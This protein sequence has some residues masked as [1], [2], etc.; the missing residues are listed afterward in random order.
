[1]NTRSTTFATRVSPTNV[2][3]TE[4][5]DSTNSWSYGQPNAN[6]VQ[7]EIIYTC[8]SSENDIAQ[9]THALIRVPIRH[10]LAFN[11]QRIAFAESLLSRS[12]V[13]ETLRLIKSRCQSSQSIQFG[14]HWHS[15]ARRTT[16]LPLLLGEASRNCTGTSFP[17]ANHRNHEDPHMRDLTHRL[18]NQDAHPDSRISYPTV[19]R[20]EIR[21]ASS[22]LFIVVGDIFLGNR[23]R[24]VVSYFVA[25]M[26]TLLNSASLPRLDRSGKA[27]LR[28]IESEPE[29][30]PGSKPKCTKRVHSFGPARDPFIPRLI[31]VDLPTAR[32]T[33]FLFLNPPR[34]K[35]S[36]LAF[37]D[38]KFG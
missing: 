24:L 6:L 38:V 32:N 11:D 29:T 28:Y 7:A 27:A 20:C 31:R 19:Q 10:T 1:M 23:G 36:I 8:F 26:T 21:L 16:S 2:R 3:S 34:K 22:F 33:S 37:D 9:C 25:P 30:N 35:T 14:T 17:V 5:K 15:Y 18:P 13:L 12:C 4:F